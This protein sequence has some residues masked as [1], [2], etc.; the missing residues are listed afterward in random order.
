[1]TETPLTPRLAAK[2]A[3]LFT[4]DNLAFAERWLVT[5]CGPNILGGFTDPIWVER[6]RA[7]ALK[8]SN[9]SLDRLARTAILAQGDWRDLLMAADFGSL[10]AHEAWLDERIAHR[11]A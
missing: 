1:M 10:N 2:L 5:E 7:A 3:Q 11:P 9:G 6:V 8:V 4:D